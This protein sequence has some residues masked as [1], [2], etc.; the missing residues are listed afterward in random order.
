MATIRHKDKRSGI[1]YVYESKAYWDK[2]KKQ[3]RST[4][5]LIGRLDV[6][7]GQILPTDGRCKKRSPS[8][9]GDADDPGVRKPRTLKEFR[10]EVGKLESENA[11]LKKELADLKKHGA[12]QS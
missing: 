11:A 5:T 1:T 8:Y 10:E 4:R 9:T 7:T 3:S 2:E 12:E 6:E